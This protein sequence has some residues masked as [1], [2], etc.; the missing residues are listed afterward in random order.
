MVAVYGRF[1]LSPWI[2][3]K[4]EALHENGTKMK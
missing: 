3:V 1:V 4:D 2:G